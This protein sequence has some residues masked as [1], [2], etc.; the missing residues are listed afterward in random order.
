MKL[1]LLFVL[2]LVSIVESFQGESHLNSDL[3]GFSNRPRKNMKF[4]LKIFVRIQF[5]KLI[6]DTF[7]PYK[8]KRGIPVSASILSNFAR[9]QA[10][11]AQIDHYYY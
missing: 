4:P 2:F 8:T 6:K 1:L 5:E 7:T 9:F 10:I 11:V 3:D